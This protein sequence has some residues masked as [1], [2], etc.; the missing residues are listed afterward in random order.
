MWNRNAIEENK[1]E[2]EKIS[3]NITKIV[4][5]LKE[6]TS[7]EFS[8]KKIPFQ[9][10]WDIKKDIIQQ[11]IEKISSQNYM[12][13]TYWRLIDKRISKIY[14]GGRELAFDN[15]DARNTK[16][17]IITSF[18][19]NSENGIQ[20]SREGVASALDVC[21]LQKVLLI[22]VELVYRKINPNSIIDKK[23]PAALKEIKLRY[24]LVVKN[25]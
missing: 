1:E 11:D 12:D 10:V 21:Q 17:G 2:I 3:L 23:F 5:K 9:I 18:S 8:E 22:V 13:K 7:S 6:V 25:S 14:S 20:V 15:S 16:D 4:E 19:N 24:G